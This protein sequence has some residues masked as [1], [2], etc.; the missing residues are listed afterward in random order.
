MTTEIFPTFAPINR[1]FNKEK[2]F[3]EIKNSGVLN[4]LK[5]ATTHAVNGKSFW[6]NGV[7]FKSP[8][9]EKQ[10]D[11]AL[12]EGE[13]ESRAIRPHKIDTFHQVTLTTPDKS[14]NDLKDVW[15]GQHQTNNKIP[16]WVA[17]DQPWF[18]RSDYPLPYLEEVVASLG[19]EYV[20]MIRIVHQTPPS[21]GV[22]H[23]DS[24][25]KTNG[26]Y[27]G[28]GGVTITLNVS[29]GGGNLYFIDSNGEEHTIDEDNIEV[30]HFDDG[31][32]HCTNEISS[33]R[34]QIRIYGR[35]KYYKDLMD[36]PQAI[37]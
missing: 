29:S 23:R 17:F 6:D 14:Q 7:N 5:M 9:F 4:H 16:L 37:Y 34:M 30:W 28:K 31:R 26:E 22:I 13:G 20:S 3:N 24:G 18:F 35:H 25:P 32:I 12:W 19:L 21:I 8:E 10:R 27:Y 33:E 2:L 15:M 36:L 1:F 11:V